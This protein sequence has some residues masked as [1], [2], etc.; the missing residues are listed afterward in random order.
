M[1]KDLLKQKEEVLLKMYKISA[2]PE[3][4]RISSY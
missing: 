1:G 4:H 3:Q 2:T